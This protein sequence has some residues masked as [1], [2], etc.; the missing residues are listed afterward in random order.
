ML[1]RQ[2]DWDGRVYDSDGFTLKHAVLLED[3]YTGQRIEFD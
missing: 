1:A 3:V 2:M